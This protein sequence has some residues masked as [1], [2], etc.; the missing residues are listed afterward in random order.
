MAKKT[1]NLH[2]LLK[3][4]GISGLQDSAHSASPRRKAEKFLKKAVSYLRNWLKKD[5]LLK[6]KPARLLKMQLV[7]SK[8]ALK[9]V[10]SQF[11]SRH[12]ITG[13]NSRRFSKIA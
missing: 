9:A 2:L 11:A 7:T 5:Q 4:P 13:I 1:Q 12:P 8:A 10:L 3:H 6:A